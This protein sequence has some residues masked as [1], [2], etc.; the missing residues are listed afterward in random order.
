V[1][2]GAI[3]L[4]G[5]VRGRLRP[6]RPHSAAAVSADVRESEATVRTPAVENRAAVPVG[7]AGLWPARRAPPA[8]GRAAGTTAAELSTEA[9]F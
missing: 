1:K 4:R 8:I 2:D 3:Q 6:V 9:S 5:V 7:R